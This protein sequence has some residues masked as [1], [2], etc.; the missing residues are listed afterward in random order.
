MENRA[1]VSRCGN[2]CCIS[3]STV[4]VDWGAVNTRIYDAK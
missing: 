4:S 1:T 2:W 3:E